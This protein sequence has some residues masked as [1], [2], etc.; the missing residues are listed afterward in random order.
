MLTTQFSQ[1]L[2]MIS[3]SLPQP[4]QDLSQ[5]EQTLRAIDACLAHA[6]RET[7]PCD[8]QALNKELQPL[9]SRQQDWGD[10]L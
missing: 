9:K 2:T 1:F 5:L 3:D 8:E 6:E 10:R 7:Q 4:G